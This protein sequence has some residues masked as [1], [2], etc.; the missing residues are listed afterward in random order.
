MSTCVRCVCVLELEITNVM[1]L[2][3]RMAAY[4]ISPISWIVRLRETM[5]WD[6]AHFEFWVW[7]LLR[8]ET[9][10]DNKEHL[11]SSKLQICCTLSNCMVNLFS[12]SS[13]C[14][15]ITS[16]PSLRDSFPSQNLAHSLLFHTFIFPCWCIPRVLYHAHWNWWNS[17]VDCL[18][19]TEYPV[20]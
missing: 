19:L 12:S 15:I 3:S 5:S 14:V 10:F 9:L 2:S 17:R 6:Q 7:L 1:P 13:C 18:F 11:Q 8:Q 4:W 20:L 16:A